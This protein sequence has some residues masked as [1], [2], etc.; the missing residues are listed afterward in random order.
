[1]SE[2]STPHS[3]VSTKSRAHRSE[4]FDDRER[5]HGTVLIEYG[6]NN[7]L[8]ERVVR[9]CRDGRRAENYHNVPNLTG[10][11][12]ESR[13]RVDSQ[14]EARGMTDRCDESSIASSRKSRARDDM[15]LIPMPGVEHADERSVAS[16]RRSRPQGDSVASSRQRTN[17]Y[18]ERSVAT[19]RKSRPH[20][21]SLIV[22][23]QKNDRRD[24]G[25]SRDLESECEG[26]KGYNEKHKVEYLDRKGGPIKGSR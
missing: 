23:R 17:R 6:Q 5:N 4:R 2:R 9:I 26:V 16:S 10:T 22:Q 1:M 7:T 20:V 15:A 3:T 25:R 21:D 13:S 19:S 14:V 24:Q 8:N 11:R 12:E 18:D